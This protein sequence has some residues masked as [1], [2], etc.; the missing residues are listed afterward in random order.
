[1]VGFLF[2][3]SLVEGICCLRCFLI[4]VV[5]VLLFVVSFLVAFD[6]MFMF[7]VCLYCC[8]VLFCIILDLRFGLLCMF[9]VDCFVFYFWVSF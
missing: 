7:G 3:F 8:L 1:M 5:V 2:G 4:V 6:L 9:E